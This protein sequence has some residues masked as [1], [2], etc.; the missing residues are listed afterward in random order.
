MAITSKNL[1]TVML[2]ILVA[3]LFG[4]NLYQNRKVNVLTNEK[5]TLIYKTSQIE[6]ERDSLQIAFTD[7]ISQKELIEKTNGNL[8]KELKKRDERITSLT[9]INVDLNKRIKIR[10][11]EAEYLAKLSDS[12]L[13]EL[14][15]EMNSG[16]VIDSNSVVARYNLDY[17][18]EDITLEG[19][20]IAVYED[21]TIASYKPLATYSKF[22]KISFKPQL[23]ILQTVTDQNI[24]RVYA[25]SLSKYMTIDTSEVFLDI[26]FVNETL[27][28][29]NSLIKNFGL[30][31]SGGLYKNTVDNM[32]GISLGGGVYKNQWELLLEATS[33]S[34]I[35]IKLL[36]RF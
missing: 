33:S 29:D 2:L 36:K 16:I 12:L 30:L 34:T 1:K 24:I 11:V 25:Q 4:M 32:M 26:E 5:A 3:F 21:S 23:E 35:G 7:L 17:K 31:A 15:K 27:E 6:S 8:G 28:T 22:D 10:E 14:N 19:D 9:K 20:F 18:D 13:L